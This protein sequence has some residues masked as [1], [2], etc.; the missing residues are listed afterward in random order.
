M[1]LHSI[2]TICNSYMNKRKG[3]TAEIDDYK[4]ENGDIT[5]EVRILKNGVFRASEPMKIITSG[6]TTESQLRSQIERFSALVENNR[7]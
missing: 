3:Y 5:F 7:I 4:K 2:K 1:D 6:L